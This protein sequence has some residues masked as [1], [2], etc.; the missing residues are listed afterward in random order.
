MVKDD[1]FKMSNPKCNK[2]LQLLIYID[3]KVFF[4]LLQQI[5]NVL[6]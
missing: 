2:L 6:S 1:L 4:S 3:M 5:L